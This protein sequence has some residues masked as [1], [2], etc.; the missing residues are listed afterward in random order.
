VTDNKGK[1]KFR[2][3]KRESMKMDRIEEGY[4]S[5]ICKWEK[6]IIETGRELVRQS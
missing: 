2:R 4:I 5:G 3:N 6:R 1:I